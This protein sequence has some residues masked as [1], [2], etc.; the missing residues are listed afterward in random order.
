MVC[1]S[2]TLQDTVVS[3]CLSEEGVSK[4]SFLQT[5][6]KQLACTLCTPD[7]DDFLDEMDKAELGLDQT[8]KGSSHSLTKALK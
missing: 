6:C 5:L 4:G 8:I 2:D 1:N 7:P 3:F